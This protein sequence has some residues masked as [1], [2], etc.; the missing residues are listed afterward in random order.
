[1]EKNR[2]KDMIT[3]AYDSIIEK[4]HNQEGYDNVAIIDDLH[5]LPKT[6]QEASSL[7]INLH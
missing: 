6:S 5:T 3:S 1:M 2:A 7:N 4:L